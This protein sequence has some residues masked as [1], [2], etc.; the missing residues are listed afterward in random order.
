[1]SRTKKTLKNAKV[2]LI[3]YLL[4]TLVAFFSRKIFFDYLGADFLGLT[5]TVGN[6]IGFLNLAELGVGTTIGVFLY[7]PLFDNNQMEINKIIS[8]LG[9]IYKR[10]G[11]AVLIIAV[12][13]S[14]FF[15]VIFDKVSISLPIIYFCFFTFLASSLLGY[16][17]NYHSSLLYT[18]Q[19]GYIIAIYHQSATLVKILLQTLTAFYFKSFVLWIAIEFVFTIVAAIIIRWK[20][21]QEYPW[22]N[23]NLIASKDDIENYQDIFKKIK[24]VFF[25][26][27]SY[28]IFTSTDQLLIY[29]YVSLESVAYYN[30][31]LLVFSKASS[32]LN[33]V[34]EG[35]KA[36]IGNLVAE[37]NPDNIKKVFWEMMS[38]RFF[39]GGFLFLTLFYLTEPF[40]SLWLGEKYVMDNY[41]LILLLINLFL[42]QLVIPVENFLNAYGLFQD[43]WAP[44]TQAVLNIVISIILGQMY[45]I[46]GIIL[47]SLLSTLLII[48]PW[49]PY[50][51]YK[52]GFK[53]GVSQ[54]WFDFI[55]LSFAF[56]L[57]LVIL[58][59]VVFNFVL[60]DKAD[61][62][63]SWIFLAI[64]TSILVI[65]SYGSILYMVSD[66]FRSLSGRFYTM[67]SNGLSKLLNKNR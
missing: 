54:Y 4:F 43:T 19:K 44:T 61:N 6:I 45:G 51:L 42:T 39:I 2:S 26:K 49:K 17:V 21:K 28:V 29:V 8:V 55:K 66:G 15:P 63:F 64:K 37:N 5:S 50:F 59:Y 57:A 36:A 46:N 30:N 1:M 20:I 7:K 3:F 67:A 22:L 65:I 40:I 27:F 58:H 32:L 14:C 52:N 60:S 13:L 11:I 53:K 12:I 34:L 38:L 9:F 56:I 25:H 33:N 62:A 41:M 10:I 23:L 18:D 35:T 47:G 24:Q 48:F 31:Y 16:F